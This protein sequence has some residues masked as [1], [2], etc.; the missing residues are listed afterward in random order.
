MDEYFAGAKLTIWL[1]LGAKA[2]WDE[3][4]QLVPG[5]L[6]ACPATFR[7]RLERLAEVGRLRS[8]DHMNH[9]GQ[10][11]YAVKAHCGLRAYGWF[12]QVNSGRAFIISHVI[13]KKKDKL[14][15]ADLS[16]AMAHRAAYEKEQQS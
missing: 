3:A 2:S 15:P 12:D 1:R 5:N 10:Q 16:R 13:L 11:I 9:E 7:A 4:E 6:A 8:P 14:D